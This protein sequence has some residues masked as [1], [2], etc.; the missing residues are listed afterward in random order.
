MAST[1]DTSPLRIWWPAALCCA[2]SW[3]GAAFGQTND[4]TEQLIGRLIELRGQVED[5]QSELDILQAEHKNSMT[6]LNTRKT[7]LEANRDRQQLQ[8]KQSQSEL[9]AL[10]EKIRALGTDSEQMLGD[11]QQMLDGVRA[12][13][14]QGIPFKLSERAEVIDGIERDLLARKV[15]SQQAINRLWAF[16]EDEIRLTRENAIY[17]QT[18]HLEGENRLVEVAKLGTAMLYFKTRD[19]R[20]GRARRAGDAW[21]YE[22]ESDAARARQIAELFDALRKQIRQGLF[23]LPMSLSWTGGG[24]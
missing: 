22:I 8:I 24:A 23:E 12:H 20:F 7:E 14:A 1:V 18:I 9:E 15:T 3:A 4:E 11:V 13:L 5:L 21:V 16:I 6:Y 2:L 17:S 19:E 10:Q